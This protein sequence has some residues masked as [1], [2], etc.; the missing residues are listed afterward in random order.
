MSLDEAGVVVYRAFHGQWW[1]A[2]EGSMIGPFG[3]AAILRASR[4]AC[5]PTID[6]CELG[7]YQLGIREMS[8]KVPLRRGPR[9]Q[10]VSL[11]QLPPS[12]TRYDRERLEP[13][14]G[15]CTRFEAMPEVGWDSVDDWPSRL[16]PLS[17]RSGRLRTSWNA[18]PEGSIIVAPTQTLAEALVIVDLPR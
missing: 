1:V 7:P 17:G 8:P 9:W 3:D 16:D 14:S 13:V 10:E 2:Q 6:G 4:V 12:L 15:C 18:H 5:T 11:A